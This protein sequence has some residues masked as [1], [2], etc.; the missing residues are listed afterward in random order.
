MADNFNLRTFLTENKLTKNAQL[1]SELDLT[2]APQAIELP[3]VTGQVTVVFYSEHGMGE[4]E[5]E[6]MSVEKALALIRDDV[7][8]AETGHA[9]INTSDID[10]QGDLNPET[11]GLTCV[12][13]V[14]I[15]DHGTYE[16]Y[17]G[18]NNSQGGSFVMKEEED[19]KYFDEEGTG[20]FYMTTIDG[21]KIYSLEDS[22]TMDTCFYAI[23]GPE[24]TYMISI[25]VS[26]E[27]V[28]ADYVEQDSGV[29]GK[30]AEFIAND[31][32]SQLE[33]EGGEDL[34]MEEIRGK[35]TIKE[36]MTTKEAQH[37][38]KGDIITSGDEIVSVSAGAK[39]PAGKV[40]V[41]MKT[42]SGKT[43]MSIWG[44]STKIGVKEKETVKENKMT[45]RDK[46]LTRLVENAL[47]IG[48]AE[49]EVG[50]DGLPTRKADP[51]SPDFDPN[52]IPPPPKEMNPVYEAGDEIADENVIPEY[53]TIE[54]LMK[55]ID[56]GTNKIAEEH[57]I[58]KM[59]A[60]AEALRTKL[61]SLAEGEHAAHIDKAAVRKMEKDIAALE[62]AAGKLSAA[63][64]KKFNKKEKEAA[65]K[66]AEKVEALQEG[67]FDLKKFLVENKL[68]AGSRILKEQSEIS[69][70]DFIRGLAAE[71]RQQG[72][73]NVSQILNSKT[74]MGSFEQGAWYANTSD[75]MLDDE[76]IEDVEPI[77]YDYC[78]EKG[79]EV[80]A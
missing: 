44:K 10:Q 40:E 79:V 3:G 35:Q 46:Y 59:K 19:Y 33:E 6:V 17:K 67:T 43:K 57:K 61:K 28:D 12:L 27:P 8:G 55:S 4:A 11:E 65:P 37:L 62:K 42:K 47:G 66:K 53:K 38:K 50:M 64:D 26:G 70:E 16:V 52:D 9:E 2:N 14:A 68:T 36:A 74:G 73:A 30:M 18:T 72:F 48:L 13:E 21:E 56:E 51:G 1:I 80:V 77:I 78:D 31:I 29:T 60:I 23:E 63:F 24:T 41:T 5:I 7:A 76:L 54:E 49:E 22:S 34:S 20:G 25:D 69:K 45:Q 32:N 71:L 39:T 58:K 75:S 15:E